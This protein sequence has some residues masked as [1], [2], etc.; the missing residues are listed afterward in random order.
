M[1]LKQQRE[2]RIAAKAAAKAA[3]EAAEMARIQ[4]NPIY[5]AIAPQRDAAIARSVEFTRMRLDRFIAEFPVG[6]DFKALLPRDDSFRNGRAFHQTQ[7]ARRN[8]ALR[9]LKIEFGHWP[10]YTQTVRGRNEAGIERI[11]EEAELEAAA[12]FDAYVAK[13]TEKVG[14]CDA[15]VVEG[16]LWFESILTVNKGGA[17]QRWK[18]QQ[19]LNFSVYGKAFN[20]WP[21]RRLK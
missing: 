9:V 17:I 4:A 2:A 18:T 5:A 3:K 12:S 20:Q 8:L 13:L 1:T 7:M 14:E 16:P 6:G 15:A 10:E 21:T 11:L 19:I